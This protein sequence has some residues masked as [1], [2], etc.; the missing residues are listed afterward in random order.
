VD[1]SPD[2]FGLTPINRHQHQCHPF[3]RKVRRTVED[4]GRRAPKGIGGVVTRILVVANCLRRWARD[5][6]RSFFKQTA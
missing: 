3:R 6:A 4:G 1:D 2:L 5:N